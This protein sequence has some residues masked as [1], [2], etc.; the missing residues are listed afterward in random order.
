MPWLSLAIFVLTF[1][2]SKKLGAD[3]AEAALVGAGT[4][5][6]GYYTVEPTNDDAIWGDMSRDLFGMEP[7]DPTTLPAS[8]TQAADGT[9]DYGEILV[10]FGSTAIDKTG[11]VLKSW[12]PAG[13]AGVIA[14]TAALASFDKKWL[15]IGAAVLGVLFLSQGS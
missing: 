2:L 4:A 15:W 6:A 13:T 14:T 8:G 12:G 1:L 10:E 9:Q 3:N 11:D 5:A 7:V